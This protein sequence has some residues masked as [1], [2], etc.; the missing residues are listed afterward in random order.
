[1]TSLDK[2]TPRYR[3]TGPSLPSRPFPR[4]TSTTDRPFHHP[5]FL[6]FIKTPPSQQAIR[7]LYREPFRA[8]IKFINVSPLRFR[9]IFHLTPI[10]IR[11]R[12]SPHIHNPVPFSWKQPLPPQ[13]PAFAKWHSFCAPL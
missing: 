2:A 11:L 12:H 10:Y 6:Y 9:I 4:D 1:M 7:K 8:F 5:T 13:A 3:A